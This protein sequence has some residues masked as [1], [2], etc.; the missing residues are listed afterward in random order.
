MPVEGAVI[1]TLGLRRAGSDSLAETSAPVLNWIADQG[2]VHLAIHFD[3]DVLD[4][5]K[6][7]PVLF[8]KPN[9]PADAWADVPRG[10]MSPDHVVRL[11]QDVAAAWASQLPNTCLGKRLRCTTCCG[12]YRSSRAR[13]NLE[14]YPR[15]GW[16]RLTSVHGPEPEV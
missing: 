13:G 11:L 4:P 3:V 16:R 7:G 2:V 14:P 10:R 5:A 9:A 15:S 1:N 12:S 8:N 6:F